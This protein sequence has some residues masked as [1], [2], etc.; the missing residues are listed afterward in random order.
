MKEKLNILSFILSLICILLFVIVSFSGLMDYS[1]MKMHPLNM[2]LYLTLITFV[3]GVLGFPGNHE[4]KGIARS[5]T[6][7][8]FTVVLAFLLTMVIFIGNLLS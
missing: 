3:L 5:I 6:T 7:M 4:W 2:V 8:I 1:I